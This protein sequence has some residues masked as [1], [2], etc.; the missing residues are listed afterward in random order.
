MKCTWL[1]I[2]ASNHCTANY[3]KMSM[4]PKP[5][6]VPSSGSVSCLQA[7]NLNSRNSKSFSFIHLGFQFSVDFD[8]E[9][10]SNSKSFKSIPHERKGKELNPTDSDIMVNQSNYFCVRTE[11]MP[12]PKPIFNNLIDAID[13]WWLSRG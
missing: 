4:Q 8:A 12:W 3:M 9:D 2:R 11:Q 10:S 7:L 5:V 6:I 13:S 1:T